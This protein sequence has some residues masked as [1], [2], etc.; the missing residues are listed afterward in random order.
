MPRQVKSTTIDGFTYHVKQVGMHTGGEFLFR[1]GRPLVAA[2]DGVDGLASALMALP[3]SEFKW[4]LQ[5]LIDSTTVDIVDKEGDGRT[6]SVALST[7]YDE[8]FAGD[9]LKSWGKWVKFAVEANFGAFLGDA[10]AAMQRQ[11]APSPSGSPP[12]STGSA[13]DS[14]SAGG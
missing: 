13:G 10:L 4:A 5:V 7:L 2:I 9:G 12:A 3:P 14:S 11:K 1:V 6:T 8:H